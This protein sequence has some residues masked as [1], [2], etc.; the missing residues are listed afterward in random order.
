M[1]EACPLV[2]RVQFG[3]G[4]ASYDMVSRAWFPSDAMAACFKNFIIFVTLLMFLL[5]VLTDMILRTCTNSAGVRIIEH[6]FVAVKEKRR[7]CTVCTARSFD[8]E[9]GKICRKAVRRSYWYTF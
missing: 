5:S 6:N 3:F 4:K 8:A 7:R 9:S 1:G 2:G